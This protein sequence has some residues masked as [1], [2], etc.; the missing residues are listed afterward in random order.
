[1]RASAIGHP[2]DQG[3]TEIGAR[4]LGRPERDCMDRE[5]VVA[6]DTQGGDAEAMSASGE[7]R[8]LA[9]GNA[10]IG[11]NRPLV[12]DDIENDRRP[13]DRGEHQ[14]RMEVAFRCRAFAD[15]ARSDARIARNRRRHR[16]TDG[17]RILRAEIAGDGE[18]SGLLERIDPGQLPAVQAILLVG[19]DLAHHVDD[20]P[21][22]R[23]EQSLLAVGRKTHVALL[24]RH[25]MGGRD[26]LFAEALM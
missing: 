11:R 7:F 6:V 26:R 16:P 1:M 14:R 20:R 22:Q 2:F 4:P 10:L 25:A 8:A 13:V 5:I 9:S 17:L 21:A 24:E 18:E 15:P 12:V 19:E 3:R 23:D